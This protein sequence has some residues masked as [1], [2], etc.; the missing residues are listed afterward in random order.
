MI[1]PGTAGSVM[2]AV[3]EGFATGLVGTLGVTI[4]D[5]EGN[6]VVARTTADI[7][8]IQ[9]VGAYGVYRYLGVFPATLGTY[10]IT[11]DDGE[12]TASE[13]IEVAD[14]PPDPPA[15][16]FGP[17]SPWVEAADV[18]ACCG[19]EVGSENLEAL[20]QAASDA[21]DVLFSLSGSQFRGLC[22]PVTVRPCS[23]RNP[24]Y[25]GLV[26]PNDH[27]RT[28]GCSGLSEV[29]L[30]GYPVIEIAEVKIDG[31]TQPPDEYRLDGY[32]KLVRLA[33]AFGAAQA[34]PSCQRLDLADTEERTFSVTYYYGTAP[35]NIA[36]GAAAELACEL[37]RACGG[38]DAG[39]CRLPA[40]TT[41]VVRQG[42]TIER[43]ALVS[44]LATKQ[45]GLVKVDAFLA[46]FGS[47][48]QRRRSA[49]WS[50]DGPKYAKQLGSP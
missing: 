47:S 33:D 19:L 21:S 41:K 30:P 27:R 20:E 37:Y 14:A 46:A 18:A 34:W 6:N 50:P 31:D 43:P 49:I 40:G 38:D 5:N 7:A 16:D 22:G 23:T 25:S 26:W 15:T 48:G 28:C 4:D 10:T 24:C 13:Y 29:L 12:L 17:C 36:V 44:F 32:R 11:W 1:G 3:A 45:T 35:P 42:I 9:T 39:E 8:E 2:E